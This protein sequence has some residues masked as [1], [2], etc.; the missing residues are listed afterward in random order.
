LRD[1]IVRTGTGPDE[2]LLAGELP[3]GR[4]PD[5]GLESR[6]LLGLAAAIARSPN[7]L[8]H[9][10]IE[11]A[12]AVT[13]ADCGGLVQRDP[14]S[15]DLVMA[16][17][18]GPLAP[19]DGLPEG[20]RGLCER[21]LQSGTPQMLGTPLGK[22]WLLA[23]PTGLEPQSPSALWV[24]GS[25]PG[26]PFDAEH[27]RL[28]GSL[29]RLAA[30]TQQA[31]SS[32]SPSASA[33]EAVNHHAYALEAAGMIGWEWDLQKDE[34]RRSAGLERLI[35]PGRELGSRD[36]FLSLV[37]PEDRPGVQDAL[38]AALEGG[39]AYFAEFRLNRG[40]GGE[41]IWVADQGRVEFGPDGR[42]AWIRG[43]V[44]DVTVRSRAQEAV[45]RHAGELQAIMDSVPAVI[46]LAHDPECRRITGSRRAYEVL[47]LPFGT[48]ISLTAPRGERPTHFKVFQNGRQ[49]A[50][51]ELPLQTAA[52]GI[53][54]RDFEELVLFEDGTSVRLFGNATPICDASGAL[55]G[56]VATFVDI[57]DR[58]QAEQ[59]LIEAKE[60]AEEAN[61]AK[62]RFLAAASH[63]LRQPLQALH[64]YMGLLGERLG[65]REE[66]LQKSIQRCLRGLTRL[67]DDL[68]D[69]SK[70]DAGLI[71]AVTEPVALDELI[72]WVANDFRLQAAEKG[73]ELDVVRCPRATGL[74]DPTLLGR[75]LSNIV[76]NAVRYTDEG[77]I[78]IGCRRRGERFRIEV[79]D[80]GIGIPP[81]KIAEIFRE[82]HQLDNEGR[83]SERGTGLGLAIVERLARLLRHKVE[84]RSW[85]GRGSVF[86]VEVPATQRPAEEPRSVRVDAASGH[87]GLIAVLEDETMVR[88]ALRIVLEGW[89]YE[90]A[91]AGSPAQLEGALAGRPPELVIADYRLGS[92][93]TGPA[94]IA[95]LRERIGVWLPAIVLTGDT[96]PDRIREMAES[97]FHL[98]H[99]PLDIEKLREA[100]Q[101]AG[102]PPMR[103]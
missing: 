5:H 56:A 80:T 46:F 94:A 31:L 6:A 70:L 99:K 61:R 86:A 16:A 34:I 23:V 52:R 38:Q 55:R 62:S 73:L 27:A 76:A 49:L 24:K 30:C 96:S 67:L 66:E 53:E 58:I 7:A 103:F 71:Q 91:A 78:L 89:G 14:R 42:P 84:V 43:V 39:G 26:S 65:G 29:C 69:I 45:R 83:N 15:T 44:R 12:L 10:L 28:L 64:L 9:C 1:A 97:G 41:A 81:D 48:N 40:D 101:L 100:V 98:L 51:H 57:S 35:G 88:E 50:P 2:L 90:V 19:A 93:V 95:A 92:G 21:A 63:D 22:V 82:F 36:E 60:A 87:R 3:V 54:V 59:A 20:C 4:S 75:I 18:V 77:R 13:G 79:W 72:D 17:R 32:V 25:P 37:H 102:A 68:L 85:P 33:P 8:P 74:S 47:R 11:A